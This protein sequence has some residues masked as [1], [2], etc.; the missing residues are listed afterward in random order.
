MHL[1]APKM[2][3]SERSCNNYDDTL[4]HFVYEEV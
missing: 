4:S 2:Q 3:Q 1:N